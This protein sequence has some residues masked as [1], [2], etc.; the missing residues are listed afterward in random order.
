MEPV[1]FIQY[2]L[3]IYIYPTMTLKIRNQEKM[4]NIRKFVIF[5][6]PPM[7]IIKT[8]NGKYIKMKEPDIA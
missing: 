7:Y 3:M 8:N 5:E 1:A 6:P 4:T 2:V